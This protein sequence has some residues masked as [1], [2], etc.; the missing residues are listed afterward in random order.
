SK[1]CNENGVR[2]FALVSS[3]GAS[4]AA[5]NF[6]SNTKGV[7]EDNVREQFQQ[8]LGIF[9][10]SLLLGEREELRTGEFIGQKV[11]PIL[12]PLLFGGLKKYKAIKAETVAK[13]M[14]SVAF[15]DTDLT[16][17]ESDQIELLA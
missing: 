14:I 11:L 10:P 9:R 6:Y 16:V 8:K 15:T 17:F 5:S 13:A 7:L 3:L 12:N 1:F 4:A 2:Y